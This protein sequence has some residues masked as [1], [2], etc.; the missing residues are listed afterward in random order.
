MQHRIALLYVS[1]SMIFCLVM[2][3]RPG[4][5]S[6]HACQRISAYQFRCPDTYTWK[7]HMWCLQ[8]HF[9]KT[10]PTIRPHGRDMDGLDRWVEGRAAYQVH[11]TKTAVD[12]GKHIGNH[13]VFLYEW[14]MNRPWDMTWNDPHP[15]RRGKRDHFPIKRGWVT[16]EWGLI[17]VPSGMGHIG[18][19]SPAGSSGLAPMSTRFG[20]GP[21]SFQILSPATTSLH[22]LHV[23]IDRKSHHLKLMSSITINEYK[24]VGSHH[25]STIPKRCLC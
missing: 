7:H 12:Y 13:F 23:H 3:G 18:W 1:M 20:C 19:P 10:G 14:A 21:R 2:R 8:P 11:I 25:I 4:S 24:S 6:D 22:V 17:H 5:T 9:V 16:H 15:P